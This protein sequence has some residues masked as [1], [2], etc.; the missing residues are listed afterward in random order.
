MMQG[1][2]NMVNKARADEQKAAEQRKKDQRQHLL[3]M[4]AMTAMEGWL[5]SRPD[6]TA[7]IDSAKAA[8]SFYD[9]AETMMAERDKRIAKRLQ[10]EDQA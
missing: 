10:S 8:E 5:S 9:L 1:F 2:T 4:F 7:P 6:P 3:D